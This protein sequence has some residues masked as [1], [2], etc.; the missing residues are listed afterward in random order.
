MHLKRELKVLMNCMYTSRSVNCDASK[1]RIE[2]MGSRRYISKLHV[3]M[4][5]KRELKVEYAPPIDI[6]FN[7]TM[8]LKRELKGE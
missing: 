5:L 6:L 4:H 1:K 8:H 7:L 2:R 3:L